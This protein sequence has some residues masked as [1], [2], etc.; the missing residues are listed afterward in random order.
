MQCTARQPRDLPA[1]VI[2]VIAL[3]LRRPHPVARLVWQSVLHVRDDDGL[4]VILPNKKRI[5]FDYDPVTGERTSTVDRAVKA[6]RRY[7]RMHRP[8]RR[9]TLAESDRMWWEVAESLGLHPIGEQSHS[10]SSAA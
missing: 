9:Q 8:I 2:A 3:Y 4:T 10:T 5:I 1:Q 6:T 7:M